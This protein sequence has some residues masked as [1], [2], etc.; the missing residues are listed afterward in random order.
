[1]N[2]EQAI[3]PIDEWIE[4]LKRANRGIREGAK[5]KLYREVG[6]AYGLTEEEM[7]KVAKGEA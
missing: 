7:D 5:L 6:K 4:Y 2:N 3:K 1:M